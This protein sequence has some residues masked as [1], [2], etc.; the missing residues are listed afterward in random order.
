MRAAVGRAD[1]ARLLLAGQAE[2]ARHLGYVPRPAAPVT[3]AR[4]SALPAASAPG[5]LAGKPVRRSQGTTAALSEAVSPSGVSMPLWRQTAV[6]FFAP[7]EAAPVGPGLTPA[8]RQPPGVDLFAAPPAPPLVSWSRLWPPLQ[9]LLSGE[10][11]GRTP[12]LRRAVATLARVRPLREVPRRRRRAW[13]HQLTIWRDR[14]PRLVPIWRDQEA[15]CEALVPQCGEEGVILEDLDRLTQAEL[16]AESGHLARGIRAGEVVLAITDLG[17]GS[18]LWR[19]TGRALRRQGARLLVLVAGDRV[20]P[21]PWEGLAWTPRSGTDP[22]AAERLLCAAATAGYVQPGLLRAL[23]RLEPGLGLDAELAAWNHPAVLAADIGGLVLRPEEANRRQAAYFAEPPPEDTDFIDIF[24]HARD[25]EERTALRRRVQA[26]I[27]A[28]RAGLPPEL[29]H[30]EALTWAARDPEA[31]ETPALAAARAWANRLA[32]T[33]IRGRD[34]A[35]ATLRS[36]SRRALATLP[37]A[38]Y[39]DPEAGP[40]LQ[41]IWMVAFDGE[42]GVPVPEGVTREALDALPPAEATLWAVRQVGDTLVLAPG[43]PAWSEDGLQRPGS[44]LARL[45]DTRG[46][47]LVVTDQRTRQAPDRPIALPAGDRIELI[48][49]TARVELTR[50]T[51]EPWAVAAGRDRYGLWA[52]LELAGVVQRMR[53]IPP[54]RFL[55]GSPESE[56]GRYDNEGPQHGVTIDRGFWLA[57]TPV[58]QALWQAV[59]GENPSHFKGMPECPVEWVSWNDVQQ[60]LNR[61]QVLGLVL[62]TEA[63]WEYACRAGTTTATWRG[64]DPAVRADIAWFNQ[65]SNGATKPVKAKPTN[66][67]GLY[68]MLGNVLEWCAD[69]WRPLAYYGAPLRVLRGA[70]WSIDARRVRAACRHGNQTYYRY[71]NLGFRLALQPAGTD[72]RQVGMLDQ[73]EEAVS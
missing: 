68:D 27:A 60:L 22:E 44:P 72:N 28:W 43:G 40:A 51:P 59:M 18:A 58:T 15:L 10:A 13:P 49:D 42:E 61:A 66:P 69:P 54:G 50:W 37:H 30:L 57:D 6:E 48:T 39:R 31:A 67:L 73:V 19:R 65:N 35:D 71:H 33:L 3:T 47:L 7:L 16:A 20:P 24:P 23:R 4:E 70:A 2:A 11:F 46:E 25:K 17:R 9:A 36:F 41:R 29:T 5:R 14:D 52:D 56:E 45:P 34:P 64:E 63:Q 8:D 55:M 38:A 53:W 21:G 32:G 26:T 62:P 1:L 12:D